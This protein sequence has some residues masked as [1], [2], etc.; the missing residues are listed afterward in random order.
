MSTAPQI[1]LSDLA[2]ADDPVSLYAELRSHNPVTRL[3]SGFWA[4]TGYT[5]T[6]DALRSPDLTSGPI[7]SLYHDRLPPGA[8]R[9]ELANRINF[10]DP[11]DHPRVRRLVSKAF[12]PRRVAELRPWI[13]RTAQQLAERLRGREHFDLVGE[14][15]HELPSLVISELL[16]VPI[17][18][19]G[20]LTALADAVTPLL[21][22]SPDDGD[23]A[24]AVDAARAMHE[25][26]DRWL[27]DRRN[28]RRDDLI[29]GLL[30]AED[31][32]ARLSSAELH[33]L[34][35][36]LYSAGHRTTRDSFVNGMIGLLDGDGGAYRRATQGAWPVDAVVK[37]NLRLHPPTH[38]V[39]R[40]AGTHGTELA[41]VSIEPGAVLLVYLA[42]AN[43]DPDA[44]ERAD[45]FDPARHDN[46]AAAPFMSF[47]HGAHYCLGASLATTELAVMLSTMLEHFPGLTASG[48]PVKWH[49]RGPFRG[50]DEF[51]VRTNS[52]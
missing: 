7:G 30:D 43:R 39:A 28:A 45:V 16:G 25:E 41:G 50:V 38:Y 15:A 32:G 26:I 14:F 34:I 1:D 6:V 40:V 20:R 42:A 51:V 4:V 11:P 36:T 21:S 8:A 3:P 48:D 29:S 37:E 5:A 52:L 17:D 49:Q 9:D 23:V 47:A 19:R 31:E 24:A 35:A 22:A 33:S 18:D 12:T 2:E 13:E 10:L 46:D 44:F 27:D